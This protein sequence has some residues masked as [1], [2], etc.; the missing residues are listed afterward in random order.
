MR[1]QVNRWQVNPF[2]LNVEL[3]IETLIVSVGSLHKKLRFSPLCIS[4][5]YA[6]FPTVGRLSDFCF[7]YK[8]A[9]RFE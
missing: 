6:N 9:D 7:F 1:I 3:K 5:F 4:G 8:L 2:A